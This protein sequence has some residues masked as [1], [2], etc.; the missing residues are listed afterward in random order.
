MHMWFG[1]LLMNNTASKH[2]Y[3]AARDPAV[4]SDSVIALTVFIVQQVIQLQRDRAHG[5]L[6]QDS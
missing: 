5:T 1:A 6:Q 3:P 2:G 4:E